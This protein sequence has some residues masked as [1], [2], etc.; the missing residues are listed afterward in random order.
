MDFQTDGLEIFWDDM[1]SRDPQKITAAFK[2]LTKEDRQLVKVHL[3]R[4]INE[5]GWHSEQRD[6]A[7]AALK[8]LEELSIEEE[9]DHS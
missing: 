8:A 1:L 9:S 4:M 7:R 6:S 5:V 3:E 2:L